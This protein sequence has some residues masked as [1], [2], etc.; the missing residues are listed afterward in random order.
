MKLIILA[1]GLGTRLWSVTGGWPKQLLEAG[2]M[3]LF[4]RHVALAGS[5]GMEPVVVTRPEFTSAFEGLGAEVLIEEN[6]PDMVVTLSHTRR[7]VQETHAWVGGDMLF[8]DFQ[9]LRDLLQ[10]HRAEGR[11][12]SYVYARTDRFKAKL[13][14]DPGPAVVLTREGTHSLSL[15][16][17]G[18][19]E[20]RMYAYL[21]DE[22]V[23]P[24]GFLQTAIEQGEPMQ[25]REYRAPVFEID[26]PA[27]L[28]AARR[29]FELIAQAS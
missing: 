13:T 14:L 15:P 17:F 24:P 16:C 27:D 11:T 2:G 28:A 4:E 3:T 21:P 25:F 7:S 22:G 12:A 19:H 10:A 29:H 8:T 23:V 20:P 1:A 9:P 5:L 18:I 6:S 26:T